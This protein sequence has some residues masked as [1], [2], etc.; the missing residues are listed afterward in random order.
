MRQLSPVE[1]LWLIAER[2]HPPFAI[3]WV[4]EGPPPEDLEAAVQRAAAANPG[5]RGRLQ[6]WLHTCRWVDSG[7]APA[8]LS[9]P[10]PFRPG[11]LSNLP[12]VGVDIT[13]HPNA[14]VFRG[15]HALVDGRGLQHFVEEVYRALRGEPLLGT[16]PVGME[17]ALAQAIPPG[18]L[19]HPP[20][21][22]AATGLHEG[23]STSVWERFRVDGPISAV[24]GRLIAAVTASAHHH[25][26]G[27]PV[28]VHVPVDLRRD[29][30]RTTANRAG[31]VVIEGGTDPVALQ[32]TV[33]EQRPL[34]AYWERS[35]NLIRFVPMPLLLTAADLKAQRTRRRSRFGATAV[36]SNVGSI[37]LARFGVTEPPEAAYVIGP[38]GPTTAAFIAVTGSERGVDVTAVLPHGLTTEGRLQRFMETLRHGLL[39]DLAPMP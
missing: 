39:A 7:I 16:T 26:P 25:N 17:L 34:A 21:C 6:G 35:Q 15:R 5:V 28:Y 22:V 23:D 10:V 8:V 33:I 38:G 4:I 36:L 30:E 11:L 18:R 3:T 37:E 20:P 29:G 32:R 27:A 1:R 13:V 9:N 12:L 2:L 19:H 14:T 31:V 24:T